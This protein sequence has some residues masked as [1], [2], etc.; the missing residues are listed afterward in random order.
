MH[1]Q[2][3]VRRLLTRLLSLIPPM[4]LVMSVGRLGSNMMLVASQVVLSIVL[5]FIIFL[6]IRFTSFRTV[7]RL[8]ATAPDVRAE[9]KADVEEE[10]G[11]VEDQYLD[12]SDG[13]IVSGIGYVIGAVTMT[14]NGYLFIT[15]TPGDGT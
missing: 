2:P 15:P 7:I 13:W 9:R 5:P 14:T 4:V 12:F 11:V 6:L 1:L 10:Q 3:L 8:R